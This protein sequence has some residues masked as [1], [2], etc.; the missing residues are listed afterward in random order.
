M[1]ASDT[2]ANLTIKKLKMKIVN[3]KLYSEEHSLYI[4]KSTRQSDITTL[5][6]AISW[7]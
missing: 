2:C 6:K 1:T 3:K 5:N 7:C 4:K